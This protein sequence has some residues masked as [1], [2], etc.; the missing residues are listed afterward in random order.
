MRSSVVQKNRATLLA[1]IEILMNHWKIEAVKKLFVW[2]QVSRKIS[3]RI[4]KGVEALIRL[5]QTKFDSNL[6]AAVSQIRR[7]S[8]LIVG[9][10]EKIEKKYALRHHSLLRNILTLSSSRDSSEKISTTPAPPRLN[11]RT[12]M[13]KNGNRYLSLLLRKFVW[14]RELALFRWYQQH[15]QMIRNAYFLCEMLNR[16]LRIKGYC[17]LTQI[18]SDRPGSWQKEELAG[19]SNHR[20]ESLEPLRRQTPTG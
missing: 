4:N 20:G 8:Q 6:S 12:V 17:L 11:Q 2:K 5:V 14:R 13:R 7:H 18:Q 15:T 3:K 16:M 19:Q 10:I 9:I 1:S